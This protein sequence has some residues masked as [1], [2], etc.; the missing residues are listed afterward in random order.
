MEGIREVAEFDV[1]LFSRS[2][3]LTCG[4]VRDLRIFDSFSDFREQI[5]FQN[6]YV[7]AHAIM[8]PKLRSLQTSLRV[9]PLSVQRLSSQ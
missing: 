5:R 9:G 3:I 2:E 1:S 4:T 8:H 7:Y 6:Y